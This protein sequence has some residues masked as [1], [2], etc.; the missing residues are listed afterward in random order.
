MIVVR[1][2]QRYTQPKQNENQNSIQNS[3][4]RLAQTSSHE[5]LRCLAKAALILLDILIE[6]IEK[7]IQSRGRHIDDGGSITI[8]SHTVMDIMTTAPFV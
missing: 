6:T 3:K 4:Q 5:L 1:T 2:T 8:M 7:N